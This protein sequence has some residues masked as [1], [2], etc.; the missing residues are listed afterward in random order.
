VDSWRQRDPRHSAA[1]AAQRLADGQCNGKGRTRAKRA[2][3]DTLPRCA[4]TMAFTKLKPKPRP[5][6]DRLLS[7]RYKRAQIRGCS[8]DEIPIPES[9]NRTTI[10]PAT[11]W[12]VR[13][14]C[15]PA[16]VYFNPYVQQV[17]KYLPHAHR[18]DR[19]IA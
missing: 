1:S 5:R 2:L 16:A 8:S 13:S 17:G 12:H 9:A 3:H 19:S 14:M 15:P 4:S 18:I 11:F 6:C 7:P 10:W